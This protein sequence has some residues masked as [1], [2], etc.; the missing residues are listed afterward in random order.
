MEIN[1][2]RP[3]NNFDKNTSGENLIQLYIN[4]EKRKYTTGS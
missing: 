2:S 1:L 3:F 4:F